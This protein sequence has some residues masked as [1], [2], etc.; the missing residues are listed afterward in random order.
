MSKKPSH[1][2]LFPDAYLRDNYRLSLEQHGLFF[3]L[4]MEAW[5]RPGCRL[6][7]NDEALAEIAQ[8]PVAKFRKMCGPVLAQWTR[9]GDTI[10]QKRL[11]RERE[12]VDAKSAA[13]ASAARSRWDANGMQMH[14]KCNPS[15]M[16]L[17]EGEGEGEGVPLPST[18]LGGEGVSAVPFRVKGGK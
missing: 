13:R 3:I 15:A 10:F 5:N 11:L 14:S 4:L 2:P 16:H 1:I 18:E 6:P 17:G 12:Y 7:G 8:V 9:D